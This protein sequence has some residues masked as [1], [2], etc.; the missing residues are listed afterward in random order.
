MPEPKIP[1]TPSALRTI[2]RIQQSKARKRAH[3][4]SLGPSKQLILKFFP[5]LASHGQVWL[6]AKQ[7]GEKLDVSPQLAR[8][9]LD[10]LC[11]RGMLVCYIRRLHAGSYRY[12]WARPIIIEPVDTSA[13]SLNKS[14]ST[15][16]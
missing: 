14:E 8:Y 16:D 5:P 2:R 6:T 9:H 10:A 11:A 1:A 3:N 15:H 12:E 4:K 13:P 7:V